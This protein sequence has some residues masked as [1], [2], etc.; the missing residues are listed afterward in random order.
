NLFI[1]LRTPVARESARSS[2]LTR[3]LVDA[4]NT[5]LN[6]WAYSARL[7]GLDYSV[8]PHLRGVTIRVGGY[9]DKLHKL[10][11]QILLEFANPDLT[12]QRF[13][14]A[15]QNLIDALEN[16]SK[17]RPVQQTSEFVQTALLE[18]TFPVEDRLAAA[19]DIT[20]NELR[21]FA[22]SFLARTDP[23]MLAHGNLTQASALN[24]ARQ[25][26]ALV[27]DDHQ[28]TNVDRARIRQLPPGQ[29]GANLPVEHPDTGYTLY[30]QGNNTSYAE[31]ARYRLLAQIIS[32]PFY[33][34]IRTTRQLGY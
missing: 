18:G 16:K 21:E 7:A 17:E 27:L 23:V 6:A 33:E 5:N 11:N 2:V 22:S 14:I 29:T 20:L 3:L 4:I 34:E 30:L 15:R 8:Y 10:A 31:R 25:V 9:N 24:M 32:S 1:S 19:R 13:R 12:E 26:Q 28:R